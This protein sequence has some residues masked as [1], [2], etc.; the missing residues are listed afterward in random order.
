MQEGQS[1]YYLAQAMQTLVKRRIPGATPPASSRRSRRRAVDQRP[2][3][4]PPRRSHP[5]LAG[6]TATRC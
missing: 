2:T 3:A 1:P 5:K 4:Q 6:T